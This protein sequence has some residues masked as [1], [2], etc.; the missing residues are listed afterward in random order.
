MQ[1]PFPSTVMMRIPLADAAPVID[2][3]AILVL[4]IVGMLGTIL[5]LPSHYHPSWRKIGGALLGAAALIF[6]AL[7]LRHQAIVHQTSIHT[8][9]F[10]VFAAISLGGDT[11]T[12][13][14]MAGALS[15]AWLGVSKIPRHL[16]ERLEDGEKGR[17]YLE[18]L[19]TGLCGRAV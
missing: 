14:A 9:Y 19:A 1:G 3:L 13:A 2:S 16:I 4:S 18:G 11:D 6:A 8:V 7:V 12:L 15:G 17:G 5:L 10:W